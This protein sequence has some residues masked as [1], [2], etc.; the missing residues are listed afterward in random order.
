MQT[1][2]QENKKGDY[3]LFFGRL[4]QYKGIDL[5]LD[6]IPKVLKSF[7]HQR[8]V[9]AG[10][11]SYDFDLNKEK[12][13]ATLP[14]VQ[15]INGYLK[16][17]ELSDL[18]LGSKFVICPYRDA[19]Q[20]GVLTSSMALGK[21]SVATNVGSFPEYVTDG[22]NGILCNPDSD[23]IADGIIRA[24]ENDN[25]HKIEKNITPQYEPDQ[26]MNMGQIIFDA[27]EN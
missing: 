21:M 26:I 12:I 6:A 13:E 25:F 4:S 5:L 2:I 23:A 18:I 24:L 3:L 7:P 22:V 10:N 11:P 9:I 15:I 27:Y 8:F 19:T 17:N 14:N 1:F 16:I 20:S